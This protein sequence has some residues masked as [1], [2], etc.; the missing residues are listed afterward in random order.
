[1]GVSGQV[2]VH[3][4]RRGLCHLDGLVGEQD[5]GY[6]V[7][8]AVSLDVYVTNGPGASGCPSRH[9]YRRTFGYCPEHPALY[10]I[11]LTCNRRKFSWRQLLIRPFVRW[12]H[13]LSSSR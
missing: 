10:L 5:N 1:V 9:S 2:Q 4:R 12:G 6:R 8:A 3:A 7:V 13:G 11:A